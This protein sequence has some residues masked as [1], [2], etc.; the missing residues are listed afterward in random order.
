MQLAD[1]LR[2][3]LR[4]IGR[5]RRG[6]PARDRAEGFS[7]RAAHLGEDAAERRLPHSRHD[8]AAAPRVRDLPAARPA[9]RRAAA[10][11]R[12]RAGQPARPAAVRAARGSSVSAACSAF[13]A[14]TACVTDFA[15]APRFRPRCCCSSGSSGVP[16]YQIYG[17]TESSGRCLHAAPGRH[18]SRL[19][20]ACGSTAS[21]IA[22]PTTANCCCRGPS[23]F[24]GYLFDEEATSTRGRRRLAAHRR[25]RRDRSRW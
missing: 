7:R 3:Q 25:H 9:D 23:V 20:R 18:R 14:S 21:T 17:M 15:A 2:G 24:K 11:Q 19:L 12:R 22:S 4:R 16:I 8:A 1:R 13:S 6:Q 5:H 10:R